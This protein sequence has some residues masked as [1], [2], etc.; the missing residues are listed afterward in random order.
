VETMLSD[1]GLFV[2]ADIFTQDDLEILKNAK[3]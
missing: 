1:G 3:K 2:V